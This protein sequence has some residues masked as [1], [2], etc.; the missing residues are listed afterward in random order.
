MIIKWVEVKCPHCGKPK[1]TEWPFEEV[2][3][4]NCALTFFP[5]L[6]EE[7][8]IAIVMFNRAIRNFGKFKYKPEEGCLKKKLF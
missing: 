7:V 8:E 4:E 1:K 3:C 6:P 2:L 5:E